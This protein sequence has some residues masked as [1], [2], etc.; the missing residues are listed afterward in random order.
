MQDPQ[1]YFYA[2]DWG[3]FK[4]K[5]P[6]MRWSQAWMM[7]ALSELLSTLPSY[8]ETDYSEDWA[9]KEVVGY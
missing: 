9:I 1:G 8:S 7:L 3:F 6:Y 4:N 2:H 5:I